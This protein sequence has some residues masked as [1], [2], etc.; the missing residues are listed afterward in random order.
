M[1][2]VKFFQNLYENR[3]LIGKLAKNDFKTKYAGSYLGIIWAFV[4]PIVTILVYWFVF[5]VGLKAGTVSDF[6]FAL[7]LMAGIIPW[8]FFQEA[9][10]SGTS[11]MVEYSYLV[12]KV[13]FKIDIL[14]VVKILSALF[15]H[16][17]FIFFVILV[18]ALNGYMPTVYTLQVIYYSFCLICLVTGMVYFTSAIM[19]FFRDLSQLINVILQVGIWMTPIMWNVEQVIPAKYLW[20]FNLNP[21]YYIVV[22]Y[23]DAFIYHGCFWQHAGTTIYFWI[24]T[25]LMYII[26]TRVFKNLQ[27]HFADVL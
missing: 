2:I 26:G 4:Q 21:V 1:N 16:V 7:W 15:V 22:G 23:R 3:K 18:Y 12:K 24:F 17:F 19:V 20:I 27:V 11:A 25:I 5:T 14:P 8:F 9:L 10:N 13:V 6:P